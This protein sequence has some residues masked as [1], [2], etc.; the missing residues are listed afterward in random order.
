MGMFKWAEEESK[1]S[2]M[3]ASA[4]AGGALASMPATR[5]IS[6]EVVLPSI[7]NLDQQIIDLQNSI[8]ILG[9][10]ERYEE[11]QINSQI[12]YIEK[13]FMKYQFLYGLFFL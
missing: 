12:A 11:N 10:Q 5:Y 6:N 3:F 9:D 13:S 4:L 8:E 7:K 1:G 2:P